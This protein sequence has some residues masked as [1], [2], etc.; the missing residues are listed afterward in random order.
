MNPSQ[1]KKEMSL[2]SQLMEEGG[3]RHQIL[4]DLRG[5]LINVSGFSIEINKTLKLMRE[6][7]GSNQTNMDPQLFEQLT[8][9]IDDDLLPCLECIDGSKRQLD[10]RL[11]DYFT[12]T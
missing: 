12:E 9:F 10:E 11:A 4:H 1:D 8:G 3:K 6:L 7:I 5:P 2:V